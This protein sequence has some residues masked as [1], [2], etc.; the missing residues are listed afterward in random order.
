[1]IIFSVVSSIKHSS[2]RRE[3]ITEAPPAI[4]SPLPISEEPPQTK[5]SHKV[6]PDP[7]LI[8]VNNN[9]SI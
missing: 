6:K 1:M 5:P 3:S 8:K 7:N 4:S 9:R 2:V